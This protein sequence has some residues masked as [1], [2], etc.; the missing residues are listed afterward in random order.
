MEYTFEKVSGEKSYQVRLNGEFVAYVDNNKPELVDE[1]LKDQ[2]WSSR[3]EYYNHLVS[4]NLKG[5]KNQLED[6]IMQILNEHISKNY[7]DEE[8]NSFGSEWAKFN[9]EYKISWAKDKEN[10]YLYINNELE[11]TVPVIV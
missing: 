1:L 8:K 3:E 11:L 4:S 5:T 10:V 6:R 7:I 9:D 2:G